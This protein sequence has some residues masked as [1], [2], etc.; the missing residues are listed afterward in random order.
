MAACGRAAAFL[1]PLVQ[2]PPPGVH[3]EVAD[4]GE[5]QAQLL[6]NGDL[7]VLGGALVLVED[8]VQRAALDVGE[9]QPVALRDV[10]SVCF[11]L[12]LLFPFAGCVRA[13]TTRKGRRERRR[14]SQAAQHKRTR[15]GRGPSPPFPS[16]FL[17]TS[18]F[19]YLM[20]LFCS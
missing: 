6:R 19:I 15:S 3:E 2:A 4:G 16:R 5:L 9:D 7:K 18:I 17:A 13:E 10:V 11:A 12:L 8:G 1:H 20:G 14:P